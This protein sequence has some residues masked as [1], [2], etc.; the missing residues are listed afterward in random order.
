MAKWL[1]VVHALG[2]VPQCVWLCIVHR[3]PHTP[4]DPCRCFPSEHT[5]S[6]RHIARRNPSD[7]NHVPS[8]RLLLFMQDELNT[9]FAECESQVCTVRACVRARVL[10]YIAP[11]K[12]TH[13]VRVWPERQFYRTI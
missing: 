8:C 11:L 5:T 10:G 7:S 12:L 9:M 13:N 1:F 2:A 3:L 6:P 4:A